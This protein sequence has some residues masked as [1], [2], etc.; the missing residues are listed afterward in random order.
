MRENDRKS[1][2]SMEDVRQK[3]QMLEDFAKGV[4]KL[5]AELIKAGLTPPAATKRAFELF[6]IDLHDDEVNPDAPAPEP[7][8]QP[9]EHRLRSAA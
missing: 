4:Q 6:D 3:V 5:R 1:E 9:G 7:E 2:P 8:Q